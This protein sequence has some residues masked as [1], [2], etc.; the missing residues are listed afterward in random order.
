MSR[1][2]APEIARVDLTTPILQL[3][4]LGVDDLVKFEW[5][6]N[7]PAEAILRALEGLVAAG[8]VG[9]DG[10]MTLAGEKVAECPVDV[11]VARMVCCSAIAIEVGPE[12]RLQLF[13]SKEYQCGEEILTIAAMVAVQVSDV[14][15]PTPLL[16]ALYS[17]RVCDPR[18]C[19]RRH[20]RTRTAKIHRRGRG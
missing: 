3:K 13:A 1:T 14:S 10:R 16:I 11:G 20:R 2:T 5:V 6:T 15:G 4:A 9:D 8:M 19:G 7:P 12:F 17:G 18:R